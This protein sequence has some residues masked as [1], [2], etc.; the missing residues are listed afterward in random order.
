[1]RYLEEKGLLDSTIVILTGDHGEEFMEP[2]HWGHNSDYTDPQVRTPLVIWVPGM[3]PHKIDR[4]TSH[5]DLPAT[6]MTLL[7]VTTPP[8]E[9]SLGHDLFESETRR[10][11]ILSGWDDL[12]MTDDRLTVHFPLKAMG[13]SQQTITPR[14][15]SVTI[16]RDAFNEEYRPVLMEIM[17]DM[18]RYS[19]QRKK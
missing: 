1:M 16:S 17:T 7:G 12:A 15:P 11:A 3:A 14:D 10:Y 6:V 18:S 13:F 5:L 19:W 4:L 9:Y 8:R 2:D